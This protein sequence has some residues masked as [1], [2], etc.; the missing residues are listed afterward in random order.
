MKRELLFAAVASALAGAWS[1]GRVLIRGLMRQER[2][3][4]G[5]IGSASEERSPSLLLT[6]FD[7]IGGSEWWLLAATSLDVASEVSWAVGDRGL[8]REP[9]FGVLTRSLRVNNRRCGIPARH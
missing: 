7:L 2:L 1:G 8:H 6:L 9:Q 3:A 5:D 4:S